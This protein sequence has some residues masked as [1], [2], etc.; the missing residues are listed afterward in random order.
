[1]FSMHFEDYLCY[2]V[3]KALMMSRCYSKKV[4]VTSQSPL[5]QDF[6]LWHPSLPQS[7]PQI[8][9]FLTARMLQPT[10]THHSSWVGAASE[11]HRGTEIANPLLNPPA[12]CVETWSRSTHR[13][14]RGRR[15]RHQVERTEIV[16]G[17]LLGNPLSTGETKTKT[18]VLGHRAQARRP[19]EAKSAGWGQST[20]GSQ[21]PSKTS[22]LYPLETGGKV[23][24]GS[25]TVILKN[26]LMKAKGAST[27]AFWNSF[28][29]VGPT[30]KFQAC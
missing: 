22:G 1:M 6:S 13:P 12:R 14:N 7:N 4:A 10:Q 3:H 8:P 9:G 30:M 5:N 16:N 26:C 19:R 24:E 11:I 27:N 29:P 20:Q 2:L 17:L 28:N 25:H 23:S 18:E 15:E 21:S